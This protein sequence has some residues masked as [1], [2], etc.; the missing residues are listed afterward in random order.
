MQAYKIASTVHQTK[1]N[2]S[3][4]WYREVWNLVVCAF[5]SV[6]SLDNQLITAFCTQLNFCF[7]NIPADNWD[8][9]LAA[10]KEKRRPVFESG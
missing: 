8:E 4:A 5:C 1:R 2:H 3:F 7:P 9:A 6:Q 10:F